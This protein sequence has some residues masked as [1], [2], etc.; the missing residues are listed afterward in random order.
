MDKCRDCIYVKY[1]RVSEN[2][3]EKICLGEE[4][5]KFGEDERDGE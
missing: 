3:V 2:E 1:I 4:C 5:E